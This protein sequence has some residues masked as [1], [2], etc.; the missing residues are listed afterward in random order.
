MIL[1]FY[2]CYD[3][4][5]PSAVV[6]P[7]QSVSKPDEEEEEH[8]EEYEP[9]AVFQPVIPLPELVK[10]VTGEEDEKVIIMFIGRLKT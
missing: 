1:L 3:C 6:A 9:E 7:S 10:V 2:T 8:P 5:E 4:L